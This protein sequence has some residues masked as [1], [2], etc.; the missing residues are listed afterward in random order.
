MIESNPPPPDVEARVR[1]D[2]V[3]LPYRMTPVPVAGGIV[4]SL[5]LAWAVSGSAGAVTAWGWAALL[6][7]VSILRI[8]ESLAFERD[9]DQARNV[10]RWARRYFVWMAVYG[11]AWGAIGVLF[12]PSGRELTDGVL[13]AV[14]SGVS[15]VGVFT[16]VGQ[17]RWAVVFL[18]LVILPSAVHY[19]DFDD[20]AAALACAG[21]L[22]YWALMIFET[23]RGG[24]SL[25]ETLRLRHQKAWFAE[26]LQA[27]LH[28]AEAA[29]AAR[30]S[31]LA[32]I[33]HEIR[34][35]LNG[36][37]GLTQLLQAGET[38]PQ[39]ARHLEVVAASAR[40]LRTLFDDILDM[41]RLQAGR[42][43]LQPRP[44]ELRRLVDDLVEA[45]RPLADEKG[46]RLDHQVA[47][48][49]APHWMAD[50]DRTRQVLANLLGNAV[51]Y[52][53]QGHVT[54]QVS[55]D[56]RGLRFEVKDTGPGIAPEALGRIFEPFM[57][58]GGE[59]A[60]AA[61]GAGL[62]LAIAQ[63]LARAMGGDVACADTGPHGSTFL[64]TLA[65]QVA[66]VQPPP[67]PAPPPDR[68][69]A[70]CV[71]VV[72]DNPINALVAVEALR[73]FGFESRHV[74]D[75]EA[76]LQQQRAG[77]I[78]VVLMD[79]QMPGIDGYETTRRWRDWELRQGLPRTPIIA[80][81]A[82]ASDDDRMRCLGCGMDDH[83]AKP[84]DLTVLHQRIAHWLDVVASR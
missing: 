37:L 25:V 42:L 54:L 7:A 41:A 13:L 53:G 10:E 39:P 80:V 46:L 50:P 69:A 66:E 44:F 38:R 51:K 65:A 68:Q 76:A 4:F 74:E 35:P 8:A 22:V 55:T 78:D 82:N 57:R 60:H 47:A 40:H 67:A 16:L 83:L 9:P 56:G 6:S 48:D 3:R 28:E 77:G 32:N 17:T 1:I 72:E 84:F 49:L 14:V 5:V 21:L 71:L 31:F 45:I 59:A 23:H 36:I 34:T 62:G 52:T 75:G 18:S 26:R 19:L 79:C 27:A 63:Q 29:H 12:V 61:G 73:S 33:S 81:T 20:P 24:R 64:F 58:V 43:A 15:A 30:S 70:V 2:R 11:V